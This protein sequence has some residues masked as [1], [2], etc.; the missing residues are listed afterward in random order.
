[1][2]E[3]CN[4]GSMMEE[5]KGGSMN[6]ESSY[7]VQ[8]YSVPF[9]GAPDVELQLPESIYVSS[10]MVFHAAKAEEYEN[11][12][13]AL[14]SW[15]VISPQ[16]LLL[17]FNYV[18]QCGFLYYIQREVDTKSCGPGTNP[19]V[20]LLALSAFSVSI[21]GEFFETL[22]MFYWVWNVKTEESHC[23]VRIANIDGQDEW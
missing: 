15:M 20:R 23:E 22:T 14:L 21:L 12:T 3:E 19:F 2:A 11:L 9:D 18:M 8:S 6:S 13:G 5:G 7:S 4:G 16:L 1:M 17:A 10:R